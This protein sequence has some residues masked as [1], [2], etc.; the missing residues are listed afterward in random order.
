MKKL[1]FVRIA[2]FLYKTRK[3]KQDESVYKNRRRLSA[4]TAMPTI[5]P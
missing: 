2:A 5:R 4:M 1:L 3:G